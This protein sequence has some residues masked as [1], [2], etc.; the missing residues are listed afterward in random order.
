MKRSRY[1]DWLRAGRSGVSNPDMVRGFFS[2]AKCP[3]RRCAPPSPL[4]T[5]YPGS[6]PGVK[7]LGH[8]A[9]RLPPSSALVKNRWSC[10]STPLYAFM[11][12]IGKS[13]PIHVLGFDSSNLPFFFLIIPTTKTIGQ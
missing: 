9:H 10:T 6:L 11:A 5:G 4:R 13:L 3:V 8:G 2:S 12:C 1:R 7:W